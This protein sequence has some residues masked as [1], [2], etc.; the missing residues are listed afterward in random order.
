MAA[1]VD[2]SDS[3]RLPVLRMHRDCLADVETFGTKG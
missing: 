1:F 3:Y 2:V